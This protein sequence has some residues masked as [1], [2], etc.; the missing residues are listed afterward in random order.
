[1][2]VKKFKYFVV[3]DIHGFY[4]EAIRDLN[5]ASYDENNPKHKLLVLGD[6]F[7]RGPKSKEVY[8]WLKRLTDEGKCIILKGNHDSFLINFLTNYDLLE[9]QFNFYNN[10]FRSTI[11]SLL[12]NDKGIDSYFKRKDELNEKVSSKV[13][14]FKAW[15][16]LVMND[17]NKKYP[18]LLSWISSFPYYYETKNYIFT[19]ASIDCDVKDFK[20]PN[21]SWDNLLWDDGGF[22]G[23]EINNTKKTVVV[24]HFSTNDIRRRYGVG[25]INDYSVLG[26]DDNKVIMIDGCT[27]VSGK[28]NV[29]I[30]ED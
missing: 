11:N 10:G 24:G 17:I 25:D 21:I 5:N 8:L 23:K 16:S 3:S 7:D 4:D 20:K 13:K 19:H 15:N 26:R 2:A 1:M 29:L 28:V 22:F 12:D 27:P 30:I 6:I 9:N 18:E 14:A